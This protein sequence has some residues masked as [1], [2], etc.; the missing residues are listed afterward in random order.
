[1]E[2][3]PALIILSILVFIILANILVL[4]ILLIKNNSSKKEMTA[5][6]ATP[7]PEKTATQTATQPTCTQTCMEIIKEATASL[8]KT[9][10][11]TKPRAQAI[12]TQTTSSVKE[13][14]VPF[15]SGTSSALDW[16]DVP[17]LQAY[18][19]T[20][21]YGK[22]KST[23]FE[24]TVRIPT[25]NQSADIRLFNSTDKHPIWFSE[26]HF[27]VGDTATFLTSPNIV[28]DAGNKLYQVQIKTQ[29][30]STTNID[31]ARLHI[32]TY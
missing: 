21:N 10:P 16:Q 28:L 17:G 22:I 3:K 1:M 32:L 13:F 19:D 2:N 18:I 14:F 25:A 5:V 7:I 11:T 26:I 29:L 31:Q 4:D 27:N 6:I 20:G 24:A 30:G 9:E 15:G 8:T 12:Q 23:T